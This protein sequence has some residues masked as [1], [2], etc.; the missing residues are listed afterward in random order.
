MNST[1]ATDPVRLRPRFS[2]E[3]FLVCLTISSDRAIE[4]AP[5]NTASKQD[6]LDMLD[7]TA[8]PAVLHRRGGTI[9]EAHPYALEIKALL[10]PD[11]PKRAQAVFDVEAGRASVLRRAARST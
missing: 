8:A 2:F 4:G 9:P 1:C 3:D 11:G 6:W 7:Y 10:R 5:V